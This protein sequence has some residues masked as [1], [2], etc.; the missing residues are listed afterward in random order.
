[1]KQKCLVCGGTM[2]HI[3]GR[4]WECTKCG[5]DAWMGDYGSLCFDAELFDDYDYETPDGVPV[6]CAAC[7][8]DFPNCKTSCPMFDD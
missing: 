1:M 3:S 5:A 4:D 7:G 2:E 8:G 6:G